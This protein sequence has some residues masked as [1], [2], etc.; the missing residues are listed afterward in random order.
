MN[1]QD[2]VARAIAF[3]EVCED[4]KLLREVLV[5]IRP[6]AAA[7]IR[8]A[9]DRRQD[10]PDPLDITAADGAATKDEALRTVQATKDL[11]LMQA[12]SR[13]VGRRLESLSQT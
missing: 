4:T 10:I 5:G 1:H 6:R 13:A 12:I 3:F 2:N 8:R 9:Q 11:A 7:E